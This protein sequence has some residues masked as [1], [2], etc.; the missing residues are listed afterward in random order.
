MS[1]YTL[2]KSRKFLIALGCSMLFSFAPQK[3]AA[4]S[5]TVDATIDSLQIMIGEQATIQLQVSLDAKQ[6]AVFPHFTDSLIKGIEVIEVAKPDTQYLNNNQRLL[7]TQKYIITSFDSALYYIPPFSIMVGKQVYK[8]KSLALKVYSPKVDL[9]HPD[10]FFPQKGVMNPPFM[11]SDWAG[12]IFLSILAIPLMFLIIYFIVR[13][14]DNKPIIKHIKIEPKLPPHQLAMKE[15]ERIKTEKV[16]QKGRSKEY[17]TELT[18]TLRTYIQDRFGFNAMEMTSSEIIDKLMEVEAKDIRDLKELFL[19]ADLVKFA[20]HDPMMNENDSNLLSA[21]SF[22]NETKDEESLDKKPV[23]TEITV[24]EKRS[25]RAKT[26]LI[27]GIVILSA[28]VLAI[29]AYVGM[30]LTDMF[31]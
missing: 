7:I 28:S 21:I 20:K 25:R 14:R 6:K 24:E 27:F 16:W 2:L 12:V 9:A 22:I 31:L 8:S 11:W 17:Y 26:L 13:Y 23:P 5:V 18:D 15:I 10:Q 30:R 19:T 1:N 4:Q 29:L 3:I